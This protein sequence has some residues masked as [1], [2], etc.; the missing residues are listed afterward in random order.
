MGQY[1]KEEATRVCTRCNIEKPVADFWFKSSPR[2]DGTK[3]RRSI[4]KECS[5]KSKL[6]EYH[7]NNG[8]EKQALR[9][10]RNLTK[11]YGISP[12]IYEKERIEQGYCCKL[13]GDHES[14]QPHGRLHIDHCHDT[15]LYRGLLCNKC[16]LAL[17]GFDD[18]IELMKRAIEYV[19]ENRIRHRN[20]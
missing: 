14:N 16:N 4:C 8:K 12:E 19:Q 3:P 2:K 9:S 18:D 20:K 15:G 17:G 13:C 10:F 5:I 1:K 7:E 11:K 6:K